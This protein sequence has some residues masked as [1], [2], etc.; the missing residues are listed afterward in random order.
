MSTLAFIAMVLLAS[1]A[2][3]AVRVARWSWRRLVNLAGLT[4]CIAACL[5]AWNAS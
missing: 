5:P 1:V 4:V 3:E 2:L